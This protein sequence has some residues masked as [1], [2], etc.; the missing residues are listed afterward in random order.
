MQIYSF[1]PYGYEGSLVSVEV[2]LRSGVSA[3]DVVGI[4]DSD[5]KEFRETVKAAVLDCGFDYPENR[6]VI[7][8]SP[9][10][11]RKY[12]P[13]HMFA[14]ALAVLAQSNEV[15]RGR[16]DRVMVVGDTDKNGIAFGSRG[17]TAALES[18]AAIGIRYAIV[19]EVAQIEK[20]SGLALIKVRNLR[21]AYE[22]L[23]SLDKYEV[24]EKPKTTEAEVP[25]IT[26]AEET[27]NLDDMSDDTPGARDFKYA[28]MIAA[29]GRLN[30]IAIG[31]PGCGKT[32]MLQC[33]PEITPDLLPDEAPSTERIYSIAGFSKPRIRPFR[34]PHQTASI[35]GMLGG[36]TNCHPGEVSIAHNGA[37][38]LDEAAE[39]K[40][41]VLQM[42][43]VP[44]ET[45]TVTLSRAGRSTTY[46][47]RF[48][49]LMATNPCPCGNYGSKDKIC[50]CSLR[51]ISLYWQKFSL[52]LLDRMD[53]RFAFSNTAIAAPSD[54]DSS[55]AGIR[56][57]V[58]KAWETQFR[59]QGKLN[60]ELTMDEVAQILHSPDSITN[61]AITLLDREGTR[62][63]FGVR[64]RA[65]ITKIARTIADI[66]GLDRIDSDCIRIGVELR[67]I[68]NNIP[69][70][71]N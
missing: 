5:V 49:L 9:A 53:I 11:L 4:S 67:K 30:M 6:V 25:E 17:M 1:E 37:L 56:E 32:R 42:L 21:E 15:I 38:F 44:L 55:S 12:G 8:L 60:R 48:Q 20:I 57:K 62:Y 13:R 24:Y 70:E 35:E 59:R 33:L 43:R 27:N 41:S 3:T 47:A 52:P 69:P 46:P 29:A 54:F 22:A 34:M 40:S 39:F 16:D 28:M 61:D 23:L 63:G 65:S 14:G 51:S 71:F 36:G 19:P 50:L 31:S 58:K 18:A 2:D 64:A 10:D 26:F 68:A 45:G 7:S 66:R